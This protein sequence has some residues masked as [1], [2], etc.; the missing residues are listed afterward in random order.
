LIITR[1]RD[2]YS[3]LRSVPCRFVPLLGQEGWAEG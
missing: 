1:Q 3:Q 2:G